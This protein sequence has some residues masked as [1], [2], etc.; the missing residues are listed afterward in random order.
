MYVLIL[1]RGLNLRRYCVD[2]LVIRGYVAVGLASI[3]EGA[4][5]FQRRLPTCIL[6]CQISD[7]NENDLRAIRSYP[8]L[9]TIPLLVMSAEFPAP[10]WMARWRIATHLAPLTAASEIVEQLRPWLGADGSALQAQ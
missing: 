1:S 9:D 4:T 8:E 6:L 2:N 5:L 3:H 10:D 7:L